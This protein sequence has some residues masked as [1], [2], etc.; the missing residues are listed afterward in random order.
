MVTTQ[1]I[2][3]GYNQSQDNPI[4]NSMLVLNP[5]ENGNIK[6]LINKM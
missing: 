4:I 3:V 6:Q 2:M 5:E 1:N